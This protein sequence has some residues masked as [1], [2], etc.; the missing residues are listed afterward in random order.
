MANCKTCGAKICFTYKTAIKK[1]IPT[2]WDT[3]DY[4]SDERDEDDKVIWNPANHEAHRC[5]PHKPPCQPPPSPQQAKKS[6]HDALCVTRAA[7]MEVIHAA[8]R[9]LAK[10]YHPDAGGDVRK[11]QEI[12]VAWEDLK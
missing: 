7:P 6:P 1:W 12:N 5:P 2:E 3:V 9:A 11:M 4:G 10:I 8:Y